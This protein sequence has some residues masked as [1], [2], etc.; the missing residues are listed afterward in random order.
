MKETRHILLVEDNAADQRLIREA[1]QNEDA[2]VQFHT[3]TDGAEALDYLYKRGKY[4]EAISPDLILLDL[5]LPKV[6]GGEVLS[7]VK[8]DPALRRIP[9]IVLTSSNATGDILRSY[10]SFANCYL[11]KPLDLDDYFRLLEGV[12]NFWLTLVRLPP[13][14]EA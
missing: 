12:K 7:R 14:S 3:A 8:A 6:D 1:F 9:I 5:N 10:S 13:R 2:A 4:A 11:M